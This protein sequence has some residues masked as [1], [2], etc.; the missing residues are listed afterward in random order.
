MSDFTKTYNLECA[1]VVAMLMETLRANQD[2][3]DIARLHSVSAHSGGHWYNAI[4]IIHVFPRGQ[5]PP[6]IEDLIYQ[7]ARLRELWLPIDALID[8]M[9]MKK[10][11]LPEASINF[12]E[13]S[14]WE[15]TFF[16]S[17]SNFGRNP[18]HLYKVRWQSQ[19]PI[20]T[21]GELLGYFLPYYPDLVSAMRDWT[22]LASFSDSDAR[23]G[24]FLLFV[25]ECRAFFSSFDWHDENLTVGI[26]V[27]DAAT[28]SLRIKGGWVEKGRLIQFDHEVP[29]V[30]ESYSQV[31][32]ALPNTAERFDVFLVGPD[33]TIYDFHRE[34][35]FWHEGLTRVLGRDES[36]EI[37][38]AAVLSALRSGEG[39]DIEFKPFVESQDT[40]FHEVIESVVAFSNTRGGM[41]LLGVLDHCEV[42]GVEKEIAR[43]AGKRKVEQSAA[44]DIYLGELR[45]KIR[46]RV[47]PSVEVSLKTVEVA[48][49]TVIVISVPE[50]KTK[51]YRDFQSGHLYV[52]RGA[53][54]V[55]PN[56]EELRE[57]CKAWNEP[58]FSLPQ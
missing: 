30:A 9:R 7:N 24:E 6:K 35:K 19:P 33:E 25:P 51:P 37:S 57:L 47:V 42:H 17:S 48:G 41:I 39:S 31:E 53:N 55:Q 56:D 26:Y 21:Q 23:S 2:C 5:I 52:R 43:R 46:G 28:R 13:N 15:R 50:G 18:G 36:V 11:E 32:L 1:R 34:T 8:S 44:Y 58:R 12:S 27:G 45:Q 16:P 54:N 3:Y 49:H 10:F 40:K 29:V 22:Q 4:S 14:N 38:E 20:S